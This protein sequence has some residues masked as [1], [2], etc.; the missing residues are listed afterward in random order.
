MPTVPNPDCPTV[1]DSLEAL[2]GQCITAGFTAKVQRLVGGARGCAHL[3]ALCRAMASAAI[4]GAYSLAARQPPEKREL[5]ID[6]L[7]HV[8]DTCHLW[9][10]DGPMVQSLK[11]KFESD[12]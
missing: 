6:S 12:Q 9:R 3:L 8:I 11:K 10:S 4:Q 7:K 5:T 2:K 1:I